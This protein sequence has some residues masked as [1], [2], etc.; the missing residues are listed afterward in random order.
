LAVGE[1]F[2][3]S[4]TQS[5]RYLEFRPT[6]VFDGVSPGNYGLNELR[7]FSDDSSSVPEPASFGLLG[8]GLA[9]VLLAVRR[10]A[11]F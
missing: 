9:A 10:Q 4:T 11:S 8:L 7:V 5:Y 6:T 2:A 3:V 1:T